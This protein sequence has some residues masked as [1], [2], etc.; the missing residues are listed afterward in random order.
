MK[1]TQSNSDSSEM[2]DF[3]SKVKFKAKEVIVSFENGVLLSGT[4]G[5]DSTVATTA[6]LNAS[7]AMDD[8]TYIIKN[9]VPIEGYG[10]NIKGEEKNDSAKLI[11]NNVRFESIASDDNGE[12]ELTVVFDGATRV[13]CDFKVKLQGLQSSDLKNGIFGDNNGD[14]NVHQSD[15][16]KLSLLDVESVSLEE[17]REGKVSVGGGQAGGEGSVVDEDLSWVEEHIIGPAAHLRDQEDRNVGVKSSNMSTSVELSGYSKIK[18]EDEVYL[19]D[20][21]IRAR[22]QDDVVCRMIHVDQVALKAI[23]KAATGRMNSIIQSGISIALK[24]IFDI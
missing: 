2:S 5:V 1:V 19:G 16:G 21:I 3:K 10:I 8:F 13:S 20:K 4:S 12:V 9:N 6:A 24:K 11:E 7:R 17:A 18:E 22:V 23:V 14:I 15:I